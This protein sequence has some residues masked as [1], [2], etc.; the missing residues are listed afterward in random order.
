R[1]TWGDLEND[2]D[3]DVLLTGKI[4]GCG[5]FTS[6]V[7]ENLGND[8]FNE[9]PSSGLT[10]AQ[11]SYAAWGDYDNDN[12]LDVLLA[13]SGSSSPFT[14]IYRNDA[15][16]P[17]HVPE[18]PQNITAQGIEN[19]VLLS[20]DKSTDNETPQDGLTYNI[21]VGS[22]PGECDLISPLSH[23]DP[24]YRKIV[25]IGNTGQNNHFSLTGLGP[26]TYYWSVQT[27]DNAFAGSEFTAEQS[28]IVGITGLKDNRELDQAIQF[29]PNP[30]D[31]WLEVS[32]YNPNSSEILPAF[33]MYNSNGTAVILNKTLGQKNRIY[34]GDL[35]SGIYQLLISKGNTVC[36]ELIIISH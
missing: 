29:Y 27:I 34:T 15:A 3:L 19:G 25:G 26:G 6:A 5:T 21:R 33:S 7:Y 32:Y 10:N 4:A 18:T 36:S 24:G 8:L 11:N 31:E 28:F 9:I 17:N 20:W 16:L 35:A 13:G 22:S 23:M 30:V 14:K 2:G 12:D 1:V